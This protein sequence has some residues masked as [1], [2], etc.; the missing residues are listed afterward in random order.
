MDASVH[1]RRGRAL[2]NPGNLPVVSQIRLTCCGPQGETSDV[3]IARVYVHC[4]DSEVIGSP[5]YLM[6]YVEGPVFWCSASGLDADRCVQDSLRSGR[7]GGRIH[8]PPTRFASRQCRGTDAALPRPPYQASR[9]RAISPGA[10]RGCH[11][12]AGDAASPRKN[13][14]DPMTGFPSSAFT[15]R[16]EGIRC[17]YSI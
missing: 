8:H 1:S 13:R 2:E 4:E 6:N 15:H 9:D 12:S 17:N 14:G 10:R 3:P 5:F 7:R 11:R 16:P